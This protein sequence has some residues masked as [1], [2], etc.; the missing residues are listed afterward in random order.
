M[1]IKLFALLVITYADNKKMFKGTMEHSQH[2][3]NSNLRRKFFLD[4][5]VS[6]TSFSG[7]SHYTKRCLH[8]LAGDPEMEELCL[9]VVFNSDYFWD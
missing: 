7:I 3:H 9:Q 5:K 1:K 4:C 2:V 6:G 8:Q